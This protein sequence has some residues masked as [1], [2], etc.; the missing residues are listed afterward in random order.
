MKSWKRYFHEN[1]GSLIVINLMLAAVAFLKDMVYAMYFGTTAAAD[2][3]GL[4]YFIT[5]TMANGL[6][7][8]A[9]GA[10][11]VPQFAKLA[12]L[13][14]K[15]RLRR[16]LRN[17]TGVV[18][19]STVLLAAGF[20]FLGQGMTEW[21]RPDL[22]PA[23]QMMSWNLLLI[24]LPIVVFFPLSAV[25]ASMLQVRGRFNIPAIGPVLFNIVLLV[26]I[27]WAYGVR[28]PQS[29]GVYVYAFS[30]VLGGLL[31]LLLTWYVWWRHRK[32]MESEAVQ[33]EM[34]KRGYD[35]LDASGISKV[36]VPYLFIL[37]SMYSVSFV[38]RYLASQQG[39][40]TISGLNYAYRVSQFPMW[41]FVAAVSAVVL[42]SMSKWISLR[43]W[44]KI[45]KQMVTSL[46][47]ILAVTV[48]TAILFYT[49]RDP[50]ISLLF[51]RGSFDYTSLR[52]T[53]DMLA[54]FSLSIIGQGI[55][56]IILRFYLALGKMYVPLAIF[57]VSAAFNIVLDFYFIRIYGSPGLGYGAACGWG[58]NALMLMICLFLTLR[59][60][61]KEKGA[62]TYE[63]V[64][65]HHSR[66]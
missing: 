26:I 53:S 47:W 31:M 45:R 24:L 8:A 2:A 52:T 42:P 1:V 36:F 20:V 11:C 21:I 44:T 19:F 25:F 4:A 48:P 23:E 18:A 54:G 51:L 59:S 6:L 33:V 27:A 61:A 50:L 22:T 13:G 46:L 39:T 12:A 38:E 49:A 65:G 66:I 32:T 34:E 56:T 55:S 58:I 60:Q 37:I 40:G 9:L 57:I 64:L 3:L 16:T 14:K 28:I 63:Q 15:E 17:T 41:V 7:A 29:Y 62:V 5:D 10:A 35:R 43:E 30:I